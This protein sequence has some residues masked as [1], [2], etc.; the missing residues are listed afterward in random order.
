VLSHSGPLPPSGGA[1]EAALL[2]TNI[3]G[4]LRAEV[5][6]TSTIGQGSAAGRRPRWEPWS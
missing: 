5:F 6:H 1:A 3:A 2:Q 4:L